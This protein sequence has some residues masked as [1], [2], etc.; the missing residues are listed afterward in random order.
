MGD[1]AVHHKYA[2]GRDGRS[3]SFEPKAVTLEEYDD[4][5]HNTVNAYYQHAMN[6]P[7]MTQEEAIASTAEVAENYLNAV[8]E[9][10]AETE[11]E[12][13]ACELEDDGEDP[14]DGMDDDLDL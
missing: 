1:A 7:S 10:Q 9:F 14:D 3:M 2:E 8:D 13:D 4:S 11:M 12:S 6:D 5:L